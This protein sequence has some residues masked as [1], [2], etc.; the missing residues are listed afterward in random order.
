MEVAICF[1]QEDNKNQNVI[2]SG[3]CKKAKK[4]IIKY[5]LKYMQVIKQ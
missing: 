5:I 3:T 2:T 1:Y 4:I